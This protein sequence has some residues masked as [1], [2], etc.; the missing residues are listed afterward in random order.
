MDVERENSTLSVTA[1]SSIPGSDVQDQ[2]PI[3]S[4]VQPVITPIV[5]PLAPIPA[6][7]SSL[8][9]PLAQLPIRPPVTQNGEV[10][11][12]DSDSDDDADT[13]INKGTGEYEISEESKLARER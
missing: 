7:P 3:I 13:R 9:R 2:N 12:S 6:V 4:S 1:E 10:G 11:S 5:P 8:V